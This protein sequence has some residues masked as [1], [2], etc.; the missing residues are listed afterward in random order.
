[1]ADHKFVET[2][3]E[4]TQVRAPWRTVVRTVFQAAV[5]L[6]ALAPFAVEAVT[7]GDTAQQTGAVAAFLAVSAAITRL[8]AVP[9]VEQ[10]LRTYVPFLAAG[11]KS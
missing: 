7:D 1:V 10:F 3:A 11:A 8:M 6:A 5:S 9:A 4:T 2:V